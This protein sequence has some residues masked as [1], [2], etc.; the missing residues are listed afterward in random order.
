MDEETRHYADTNGNYLGGFGSGAVPDVPAVEVSPP[1]HG[2]CIWTPERG[3]VWPEERLAFRVREK[4]DQLLAESDWTQTPDAPLDRAAWARYRQAL[5]DVTMQ[6]GFPASVVWPEPPAEASSPEVERSPLTRRQLFIG[7]YRLGLL[8]ATETINAAVSG[9]MPPRLFAAVKDLPEPEMVEAQ[10]TFATFT[11]ARRS[12][13]MVQLLSAALGLTE[14][15]ADA[16]WDQF[17]L[18]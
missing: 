8:T 17:T 15:Q 4:R 6:P 3:W 11:E 16:M 13:P 1:P 18:V 2:D 5:R 7:L 10:I 12:D 9:A 14:K